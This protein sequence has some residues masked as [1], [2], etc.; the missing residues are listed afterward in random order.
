MPKT[1]QNDVLSPFP[2]KKNAACITIK[3][4]RYDSTAPSPL[5]LVNYLNEMDLYIFEMEMLLMQVF[6]KCRLS[7]LF[8]AAMLLCTLTSKWRIIRRV[9]TA[10]LCRVVS[11]FK[12]LSVMQLAQLLSN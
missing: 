4:R 11:L 8:P 2:G 7:F 6:C 1:V 10:I 3:K 9:L 5:C 12:C